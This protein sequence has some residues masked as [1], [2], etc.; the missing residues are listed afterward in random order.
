MLTQKQNKSK[1]LKGEKQIMLLLG[2]PYT[3]ENG[4]VDDALIDS[5]TEK[6]R[7]T[8]LDWIRVHIHKSSYINHKRTSYSLKHLFQEETGIY[9][10]NN[11][12]K[13]AMI[14][15][16][17]YPADPDELNWHYAISE[18]WLKSKN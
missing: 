8:L 14:E 6:E 15:L 17:F 11:Q 4:R 18:K 16:D 1:D 2:R 10:T 12:F 13:D 7:E 3:D 9:V 5:L